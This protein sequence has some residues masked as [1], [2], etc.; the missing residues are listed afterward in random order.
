MKLLEPVR[1]IDEIIAEM[2]ILT[3][4]EIGVPEE[5]LTDEM[6]ATV[7]KMCLEVHVAL[8]IAREDLNAILVPLGA[9]HDGQ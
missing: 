6:K 2:R 4:K 3:A 9:T 1:D 7:E 8:D 5:Y